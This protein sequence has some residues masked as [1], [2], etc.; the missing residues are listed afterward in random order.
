MPEASERIVIDVFARD[1]GASRT[2]DEIGTSAGRAG[3]GIDDVGKSATHLDRDVDKTREHLHGLIAEFEKTGDV[4][5]FKDIRK[6]RSQLSLLESMRKELT[7]AV[8]V[9]EEAEQAGATAGKQFSSGFGDVIGAL[10][11][12]IKGSL[13]LGIAGLVAANLPV[14][15]AMV[16]GAVLGGVGTGGIVGGIALAAQDP[17]IG[18]TAAGV[19]QRIF[20]GLKNEAAVDIGGPLLA[21]LGP[22]ERAGNALTHELGEGFRELAPTIQPLANGIE[23]FVRA[24]GPGLSKAFKAAE[25]AMR[26]LGREL[27]ELGAALGDALADIADS[28]DGA[29]MGLIT[30]LKLVEGA[31]RF[32][33][34]FVATLADIYEGLVKAAGAVAEFTAQLPVVGVLAPLF[35]LA[36]KGAHDLEGSVADA[37]STGDSFVGTLAELLRGTDEVRTSTMELRDAMVENAKVTQDQFDPTANL[38]HRL[39]DI[40]KAQKDYTEAVKEH[41]RHSDEAKAANLRLAE[42]VLA[43]SAASAAAT[44]TFDGKLDPALKRLLKQAGVTAD[45]INDLERQA[46]EAHK[47]LDGLAGDYRIRIILQQQETHREDA[48]QYRAAGGPVSAGRSY[49]VGENGPEMVTFGRSGMVHNAADTRAMMSG[50]SGGAAAPVR[51]EVVGRFEGT[52]MERDLGEALMRFVRYQVRVVGGG[53]VQAAYGRN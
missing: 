7:A 16:A 47:A 42:A 39:D 10:P 27:P 53:D 14:L 25:P 49:V 17:A 26:A 8:G 44:G 30:L 13:M 11:S 18:Q 15:G 50:A 34:A 2:F 43:A 5:L 52:G 22:L 46:R 23:G 41:G 24:L 36:A 4:Q 40:K 33:G 32:G 31:I 20:A 48:R 28:S 38:I 12:E 45:E 29:I 1:R 19:F 37:K 21:S 3:H 9:A 51:L 6:D 35:G